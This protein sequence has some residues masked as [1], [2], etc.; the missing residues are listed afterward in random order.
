MKR[1]IEKKIND[2][3]SACHD[4]L[5]SMRR[6]IQAID[7]HSRYLLRNYGLTGPQL[8]I[9]QEMAK[10]KEISIGELAKSISLGQATV[11]GILT[12]LENRG[13]VVRRRSNSDKR[14]VF[15]RTTDDCQQLLAS[16]PPPI[17]ETFM[18]QFNNLLDWEQT[19]ILSALQRL[20]SMIGAS[21][22][23]AEPILATEPLTNIPNQIEEPVK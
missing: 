16:A 22:L 18:D 23:N 2:T 3:R 10:Y 21:A 11:T 9:L 14:R 1:M 6:I 7:L 5:V 12:R 19:L 15:V 4:V 13:L 8:V 17:Q 20:V